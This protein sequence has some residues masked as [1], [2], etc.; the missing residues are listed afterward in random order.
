MSLTVS[1]AS[2]S[3][4]AGRPFMAHGMTV[5]SVIGAEGGV[6]GNATATGGAA[7][8]APGEVANGTGGAIGG[9]ALVA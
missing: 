4:M 1:I 3:L 7:G 9:A 2:E 6:G 5:T 8:V